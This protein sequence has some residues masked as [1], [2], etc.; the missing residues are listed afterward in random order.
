MM[1]S[2]QLNTII[3]RI[4]SGAQTA[5]DVEALRVV[6]SDRSQDLRQLG[7]YN[8]NIGQGQDIHIGDRTYV[9]WNEIYRERSYDFAKLSMPSFVE[10]WVW[11]FLRGEPNYFIANKREVRGNIFFK[12]ILKISFQSLYYC[13]Q[14]NSSQAFS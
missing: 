5:T 12:W 9:T 8:I 11:Y 10:V 4:A 2:E 1:S 6:L 7:K 13:S 14:Q 3:E